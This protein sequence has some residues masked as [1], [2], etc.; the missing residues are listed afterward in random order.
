MTNRKSMQ[1]PAS[2]KK[3]REGRSSKSAAAETMNACELLLAEMRARRERLHQ[4]LSMIHLEAG[5][6][7]AAPALQPRHKCLAIRRKPS[8]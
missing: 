3:L 7:Y 8:S 1:Q 5:A 6:A 4:L 2:S